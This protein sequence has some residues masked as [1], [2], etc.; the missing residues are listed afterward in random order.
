MG[1]S[2]KFRSSVL[3]LANLPGQPASLCEVLL[4]ERD[5][6]DG[7]P[8]YEIVDGLFQ[9]PQRDQVEWTR[10]QGRS[11]ALRVLATLANFRHFRSKISICKIS[12]H[13][14]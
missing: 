4:S 8:G 10:D 1:L 13:M 2:L 11:T 12:I 6:A 14:G 9:Y 7:S 5:A 3:L